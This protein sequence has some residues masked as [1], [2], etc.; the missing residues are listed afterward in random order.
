MSRSTA[1]GPEGSDGTEK[2]RNPGIAP[3]VI[4]YTP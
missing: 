2:I 3:G 1:G 4:G